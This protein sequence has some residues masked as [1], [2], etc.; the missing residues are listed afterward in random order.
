MKKI[1]LIAVVIFLMGCAGQRHASR[2]WNHLKVSEYDKAISE[3]EQAKESNNMPGSYLGL[4]RT[5]IKMGNERKAVESLND[6]LKVHPEDG[7]LNWDMGLYLL[8][9]KNNPCDA[10]TYLNN[11]QKSRVG[12]GTAAG[13]VA[14]DVA[15]AK[16]KCKKK[17]GRQ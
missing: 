15:E 14:S 4:F 17:S 5:Y 12:R 1:C 13:M 8:K 10:L 2:G 7:F 11:T 16:E 9:K 6:G 3:F